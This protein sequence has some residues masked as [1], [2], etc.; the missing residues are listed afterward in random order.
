MEHVERVPD[1]PMASRRD[2]EAA[3]SPPG[4]EPQTAKSKRR[5]EDSSED[6][7]GG[8]AKRSRGTTLAVDRCDLPPL[9]SLLLL[10]L[11]LL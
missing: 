7:S 9:Y 4:G 5:A 1:L 8:V 10:V 11:I 6:C 2:V 3:Q